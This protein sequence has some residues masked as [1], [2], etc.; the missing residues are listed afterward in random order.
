VWKRCQVT[1]KELSGSWGTGK[2][3]FCVVPGAVISWVGFRALPW[4]KGHGVRHAANQ[5][6]TPFSEDEMTSLK[7]NILVQ[8]PCSVLCSTAWIWG[9]WVT[10]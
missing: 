4:M 3:S 1:K 2:K 6:S 7:G 5:L 8:V 10:M 9:P